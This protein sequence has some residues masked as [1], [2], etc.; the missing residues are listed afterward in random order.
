MAL[1]K[2]SNRGNAVDSLDAGAGARVASV[3]PAR[4]ATRATRARV[5]NCILMAGVGREKVEFE[6]GVEVMVW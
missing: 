6:A 5:K 1:G 4:T 2:W 3:G